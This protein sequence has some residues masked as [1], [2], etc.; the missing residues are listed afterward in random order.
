MA[1]R[2]FLGWKEY[3]CGERN[4]SGGLCCNGCITAA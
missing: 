4:I 2:I 1:G 3:F